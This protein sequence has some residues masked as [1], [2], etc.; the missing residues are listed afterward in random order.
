VQQKSLEYRNDYKP[1]P[2]Y[3][4]GMAPMHDWYLKEWLKT[5]GKKQ[6]DIVRD[7]EWN[8]ARI[9]LMIRGDQQYNRDA[10]NELS[11]YLNLRPHELLMHPA[12]AMALRKLQT[13]AIE[14]A[15]AAED[16]IPRNGTHG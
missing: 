15:H 9:S 12:D 8:K 11:T 16:E 1:T 4:S 6:A 13:T 10:I 3:I 7:L 14:I 5:L 2:W